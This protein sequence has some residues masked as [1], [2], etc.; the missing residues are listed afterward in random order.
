MLFL[1]SSL[2]TIESKHICF[3]S[4]FIIINQTTRILGCS[5]QSLF[6][7]VIPIEECQKFPGFCSGR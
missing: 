2:N 4:L 1:E 6:L 5:K 3:L 7:K